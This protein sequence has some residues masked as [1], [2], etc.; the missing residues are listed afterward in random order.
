[1]A[2]QDQRLLCSTRTQH[3]GLKNPALPQQ[4]HMSQM[5]L[6]LIPGPGTQYTMGWPKI[7]SR[8]IWSQL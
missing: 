7:K 1:M 2:Q 8:E 4:Q 6:D 5:Q 3:S